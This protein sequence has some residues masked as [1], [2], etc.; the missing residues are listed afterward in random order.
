[1]EARKKLRQGSADA[2]SMDSGSISALNFEPFK[3]RPLNKAIFER[4]ASL[5]AVEKKQKTT[6]EQFKLSQ[7]NI[8]LGAKTLVEYKEEL[9]KIEKSNFKARALNKAVLAGVRR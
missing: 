2:Q 1:M 4:Q 9:E 7:T 8:K 3:A 5:P 6:F